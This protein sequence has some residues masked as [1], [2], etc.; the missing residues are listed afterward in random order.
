MTK[1]TINETITINDTEKTVL[2]IDK[3][4]KEQKINGKDKN[5]EVNLEKTGGIEHNKDGS[6]KLNFTKSSLDKSTSVEN[7]EIK[8]I[9]I[10]KKGNYALINPFVKVKQ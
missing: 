8:N 2:L 10:F 9:R 1:E 4:T 6:I 3:I 7:P 5:I